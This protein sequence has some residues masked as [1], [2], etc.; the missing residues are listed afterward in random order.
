[1]LLVGGGVW[2]FTTYGPG[3][4]AE[5]NEGGLEINIGAN[6]PDISKLG[7]YVY[8]AFPLADVDITALASYTLKELKKKRAAIIYV[9]NDTGIEAAKVYR[10]VFEKGGGQIVA[11][12]TE[13]GPLHA[14]DV[15][16]CLCEFDKYERTRL[17]EGRPRS[18][19]AGMGSTQLG[20]GPAQQYKGIP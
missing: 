7:E 2:W 18:L 17:G 6:S 5:P 8:T 13:D 10:S 12:E 20:D 4:P 11:Y 9:N 16:N 1:M 15:E 14:Q 19:Y 3:A